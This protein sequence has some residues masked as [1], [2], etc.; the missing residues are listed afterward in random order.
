MGGKAKELEELWKRNKKQREKLLD[1]EASFEDP[2]ALFEF[3][4]SLPP[5]L[6]V[7]VK[8]GNLPVK[9]A[10]SKRPKE[11]RGPPLVTFLLA[12]GLIWGDERFN[13]CVNAL[14]EHEIVDPST[15]DFT[16]K[17]G[18]GEKRHNEY[19]QAKCLAEVDARIKQCGSERQ[20]CDEVAAEWAWPGTSFKAA[21]QQLRELYR[22]SKK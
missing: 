11:L 7:P 18:P 12:Q 5:Q 9:V 4:Q 3:I 17:Q 16:G 22:A 14:F 1:P 10:G 15:H 21:A 6:K 19:Y 2:K 20:A 8:V 13:V